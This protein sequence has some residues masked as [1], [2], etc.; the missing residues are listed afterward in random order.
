MWVPKSV[1]STVFDANLWE[2]LCD[3]HSVPVT[4]L[5][6]GVDAPPSRDMATVCVAGRR[7]DGRLHVEW[8][9]TESGVTFLPDWVANHLGPQV[10]AVVVDERGA[11][12]DLDWT[13]AKI[14]PTMIGTR[15]VANAAG[16]LWDSVADGV[17]V[18]RG[19]LELSRAVLSAKQR[20]M[21]GG[22]AFGWD[23]KAPGS[24]VLVAASLA[25][26]GVGCVRPARPRRRE[27]ERRAVIVL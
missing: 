5:A 23:R 27:G 20:P 4:D 10:R 11:L 1:E 18:H 13:G 17:F 3:P 9:T 15:D 2:S 25:L 12:S 19:Q 7:S 22:Q 14:R 16:L 24:S 21:L 6:L 26:W 8:Y